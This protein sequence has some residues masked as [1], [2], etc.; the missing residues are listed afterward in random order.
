MILSNVELWKTCVEMLIT[1]NPLSLFIFVISFHFI[2]FFFF[3]FL[4]LYIGCFVF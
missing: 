3:I 4:S 2:F 1:P